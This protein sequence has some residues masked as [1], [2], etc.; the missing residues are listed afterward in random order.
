MAYNG[1]EKREIFGKQLLQRSKY[2]AKNFLKKELK[3][4]DFR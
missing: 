3:S 1:K 2:F 4:K